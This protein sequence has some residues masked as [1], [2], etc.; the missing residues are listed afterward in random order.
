MHNTETYVDEL[1]TPESMAVMLE[2]FY[3]RLQDVSGF[4]RAL[5]GYETYDSLACWDH[6]CA[7]CEEEPIGWKDMIVMEE[8]VTDPQIKAHTIPFS[9][10]YLRVTRDIR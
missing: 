6:S 2:A 7:L 3:H 9:P 10:G 8:L 5:F 1:N 4:R